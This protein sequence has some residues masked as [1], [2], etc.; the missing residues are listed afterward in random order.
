LI[1]KSTSSLNI[2]FITGT[3]STLIYLK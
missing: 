3:L 1:E 2:I